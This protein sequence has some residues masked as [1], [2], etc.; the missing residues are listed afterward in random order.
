M[1]TPSALAV[2]DSGEQEFDEVTA[3]FP[4]PQTQFMGELG[5]GWTILCAKTCAHYGSEMEVTPFALRP[6]AVLKVVQ[7]APA[8][9]ETLTPPEVP[10]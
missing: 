1:E 5:L 7:V 4:P 10:T 6:F 9:V 8:S 2:R 3:H